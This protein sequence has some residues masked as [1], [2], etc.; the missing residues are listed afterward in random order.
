MSLVSMQLMLNS[1]SDRNMNKASAAKM[2]VK[3][4]YFIIVNR[5]YDVLVYVCLK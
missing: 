3:C 4:L 5:F 2:C 1:Q